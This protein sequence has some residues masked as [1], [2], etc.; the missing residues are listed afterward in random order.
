MSLPERGCI[1]AGRKSAR[2][3]RSSTQQQRTGAREFNS[4]GRIP[5]KVVVAAW[6][7]LWEARMTWSSSA[8]DLCG[9]RMWTYS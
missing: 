3:G 4:T 2:R 5:N 6:L 1:E 8:E 9:K 7:S